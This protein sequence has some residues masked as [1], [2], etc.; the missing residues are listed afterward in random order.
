MEGVRAREDVE[1]LVKDGSKAD[2][3]SLTRVDCNMLIAHAS[4]LIP[5]LLS[6]LGMSFNLFTQ[7]FNLLLV[8][9][10]TL[11]KML[12]HIFNFSI[13]GEHVQ[14]VLYLEH[15]A[16]LDDLQCFFNVDLSFDLA[17]NEL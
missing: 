5:Q 10:Q 7:T 17:L 3:T 16:L 9:V 4:L 8:V 2:V 1:L 15:V 12:L 14:N 11:T 13:L 6:T